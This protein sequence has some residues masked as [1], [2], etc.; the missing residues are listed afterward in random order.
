M[1]G[2]SQLDI[3]DRDSVTDRSHVLNAQTTHKESMMPLK[4]K[5]ASSWL[6]LAA[7]LVACGG[8]DSTSLHGESAT[9]R[10]ASG[11]SA[12]R[13]GASPLGVSH[14]D[15]TSQLLNWAEDQYPSFF[16]THEATLASP[17]FLYRHYAKSGIYVGVAA[18][19]DVTYPDGVYV[20]GGEFGP[21]PQFVGAVNSFITPMNQ[22]SAYPKVSPWVT[23]YFVYS[24][25]VTPSPS[26]GAA[27]T[28]TIVTR[29][30]RDVTPEGAATRVDSSSSAFTSQATRV[31]DS[32]GATSTLSAGI[33]HCT[34]TP[35]YRA[36]PSPGSVVEDRGSTA[37]SESCNMGPGTSTT[38]GSYSSTWLNSAIELVTV[39]AGTF[40]TFK[41]KI[42]RSY[43]DKN[44]T[45]TTN[46]TCWIDLRT[47]RTAKCTSTYLNTPAGKSVAPISGSTLFELLAFKFHGDQA[48]GP[49]VSRFVGYW[50][51]QFAG[52]ATGK[53]DNMQIDANGSISGFCKHLLS[54]GLYSNQYAVH[55]TVDSSGGATLTADTGAV[56]VGIF[57]SPVSASGSWSN[58]SAIGSWT[59]LHI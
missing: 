37:S 2:L 29:S 58:G 56:L 34:Y 43:S 19:G 8:G 13:L 17:P 14:A 39:P 38:V 40:P 48:V 31:L 16:P 26:S 23:D 32:N 3:G 51:V 52:S 59:A 55:G 30:Y 44:G 24:N 46:E 28:S 50:N 9:L 4:L 5:C 33:N 47:G 42:V 22:S 10:R 54:T 25:V 35:A 57:E 53:C 36:T 12:K 21:A 18:G 15:A 45:A 7:L 11:L 1:V 27:P 6:G 49:S 41:Y 20:M